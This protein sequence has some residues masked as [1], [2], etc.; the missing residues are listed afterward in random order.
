MDTL[1]TLLL[2]ILIIL[3]DVATGATLPAA[4]EQPALTGE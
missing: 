3:T 2:G 1:T 4:S